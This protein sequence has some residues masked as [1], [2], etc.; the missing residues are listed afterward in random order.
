MERSAVFR[1]RV[2]AR[3]GVSRPAALPRVTRLLDT[4]AS[5]GTLV[6][7][8]EGARSARGISCS[9]SIPPRKPQGRATQ[10]GLNVE[11]V[12]ILTASS[13]PVTM[14]GGTPA[15]QPRTRWHPSGV[16]VCLRVKEADTAG[17]LAFL[18]IAVGGFGGVGS[19]FSFFGNFQIG[20]TSQNNLLGFDSSSARPS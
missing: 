15:S 13:S 20:R 8:G 11:N 19:E 5:I 7:C 16:N 9:P 14:T 10:T 17:L 18:A 2:V 6:G 1:A 4:P 3:L 12:A